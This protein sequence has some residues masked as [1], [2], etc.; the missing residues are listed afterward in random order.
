VPCALLALG[1]DA[2]KTLVELAAAFDGRRAVDDRGEQRMGEAQPVA[3]GDEHA[4]LL[5]LEERVGPVA[6]SGEHLDDGGRRRAGERRRNE[7]GTPRGLRQPADTVGDER[8]EA[9]RDGQRLAARLVPVGRERPRDLE[10]EERVSADR[11]DDTPQDGPG[12]PDFELLRD[13]AIQRAE[14]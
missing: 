12:K 11:V 6:V 3:L 5:R 8:L 7:R 10:R 9:A 14:A 1:G 13:D 2:R 4:R